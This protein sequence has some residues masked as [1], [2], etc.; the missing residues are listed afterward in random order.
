MGQQRL[1]QLLRLVTLQTQKS[2]LIEAAETI[3][4]V[5]AVVRTP[6]RLQ[7]IVQEVG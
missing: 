2:R 6:N 1:R 3:I 7:E 4:Q 5:G